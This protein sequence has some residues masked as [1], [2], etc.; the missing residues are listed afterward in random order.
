MKTVL[1]A[2]L[3]T[4]ILENISEGV[5]TVD[6]GWRMTS[7]NRAAGALVRS[8][9]RGSLHREVQLMENK[10]PLIGAQAR[11]LKAE[12][13]HGPLNFPDV[14]GNRWCFSRIQRVSRRY[15]RRNS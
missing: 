7:F 13:T 5:F 9:L 2:G 4:A 14:K 1:P 11:S 12:T 3:T 15:V 6:R 10:L 8:R